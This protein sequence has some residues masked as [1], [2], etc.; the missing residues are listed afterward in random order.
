MYN[1][2]FHT[3]IKYTMKLDLSHYIFSVIAL[4]PNAV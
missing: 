4:R 3:K 1:I 2:L